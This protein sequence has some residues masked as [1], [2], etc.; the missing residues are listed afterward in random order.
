MA[1]IRT[2]KPEFWADEKLAPLSPI[3]RLTFLGLISMADDAGRLLDNT[4]I[5]DAFVFPYTNHSTKDALD[6]LWHLGRIERGETESGQRIIEIAKWL[7]HQKIDHANK[8]CLPSIAKSSRDS[9]EIVAIR[10][11]TIDHIPTTT[12]LRPD[13]DREFATLREKYPKR[14]GAQGWPTARD[15]YIAHRRSGVSFEAVLAGVEGYAALCSQNGQAGT[16]YVCQATTFFGPQKR[17]EEEYVAA[18]APPS[19][20]D[21]EYE[22]IAA[23]ASDVGRMSA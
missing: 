14:E 19:P 10:P 15:R 5:I 16:R 6:E 2:V 1:R 17:W 9:R 7:T 22:R 11:G 23:E 21:A 3:T 8:Y 13:F 4:K 18:P 20:M 12:D